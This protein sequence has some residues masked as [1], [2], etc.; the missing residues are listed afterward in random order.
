M[1]VPLD[2]IHL[3]LVNGRASCLSW[4]ESAW[5]RLQSRGFF[6]VILITTELSIT[7]YFYGQGELVYVAILVRSTHG[8]MCASYSFP[9]TVAHPNRHSRFSFVPSGHDVS[10][11]LVLQLW[12]Y[13]ELLATLAYL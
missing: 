9:F 13:Q 11:G 5:W 4:L 7:D 10:R 12:C 1:V 2:V 3:L 6:K 8:M